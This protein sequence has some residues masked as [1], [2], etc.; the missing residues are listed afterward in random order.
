MKNLKLLTVFLLLGFGLSAQEDFKVL[1]WNVQ[2][3]PRT[4]SPFSA[5]LRKGQK[6]RLPKIA[7]ACQ[8]SAYDLVLLQE[9]F[10]RRLSRRLRRSLRQDYPYQYKPRRRPFRLS[11]GLLIL[12]RQ[13][14]ELVERG[15]FRPRSGVDAIASKGYVLIELLHQG[16]KIQVMNTHLQADDYPKAVRKRQAQTQVLAQ[17]LNRWQK[18]AVPQLL[19][20]DLN[21]IKSDSATYGFMMRSLEGFVD[22]PF[23][24]EER[25]YTWDPLNS[26]NGGQEGLGTQLDYLLWRG[27]MPS[28]TKLRILR[29]RFN[30]KGKTWDYADHYG[31]EAQLKLP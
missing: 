30:Y 13:P 14:F 22:L 3:L 24:A 6:V 8:N 15:F 19:A 18:E 17:V 11:S 27:A 29:P 12:S 28:Q 25:P 16:K 7:E 5:A 26:W 10:D 23:E 31:I 20:G 21:T 1:T 9:V 2:L 4:L